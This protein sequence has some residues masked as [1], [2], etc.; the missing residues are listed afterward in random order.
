MFGK[1]RITAVMSLTMVVTTAAYTAE[2]IDI[3]KYDMISIYKNT[4]SFVT[5]ME[6]KNAKFANE[7]SN[8]YKIME[9]AA[10]TCKSLG[11]VKHTKQDFGDH[12]LYHYT[13]MVKNDVE[14]VCDE[15]IYKGGTENFA[16]L[17]DGND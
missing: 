2:K 9:K 4:P 5:K 10:L 15:N 13:K 7:G 12:V 11:F 1:E 17:V 14:A 8:P 16:V 6:K 3:D